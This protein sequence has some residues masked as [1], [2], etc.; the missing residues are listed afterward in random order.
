MPF[1]IHKFQQL[2]CDIYTSEQGLPEGIISRITLQNGCPSVSGPDGG[3]TL[4]NKKWSSS[5]EKDHSSH[6]DH[7]IDLPEGAPFEY[8]CCHIISPCGDEWYGGEYGVALKQ[9]DRWRYFYGRRWL[10]DNHVRCIISDGDNGVWAGTEHGISHL[11]TKEMTLK[12]KARF[13]QEVTEKRHIRQGYVAECALVNA[14]DTSQYLP[15]ATPNEGLWTGLYTASQCFRFAATGDPSAAKNAREAIH[16]MI[17]LIR[18]TG[19]PGFMARSMV[20]N[21]ER[22]MGCEMKNGDWKKGHGEY[23]DYIWR[24]DPSSDEVDGHYLAWYLY[25]ELVADEE[26]KGLIRSV[27]KEVTD[28]ILE[29]DFYLVGPHGKTTSWGIWAPEKLNLDPEWIDERGLNSLEILSH[30]RVAYHICGE[31]RYEDAYRYL[32]KE[33][34]YA[35]NLVNQKMLPPM[36]PDN[37]S[38]D[39]LAWCAYYPLLSIENDPELRKIYLLSLEKTWSILKPQKSPFHNFLYGGLT[40]KPCDEEVS[41]HWLCDAPLD[42][43]DWTMLNSHRKDIEIAIERGRLGELQTNHVLPISEKAITKWNL[44]PYNLDGGSGGTVELDGT[45]WLLPYWFGRYHH[46]FEEVPE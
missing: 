28:H 38:D 18:V 16:A 25:Y 6:S 32:I 39:E 20:A 1:I 34:G 27:C 24:D 2:C 40:G 7:L 33:H 9:G 37:H 15:V 17:R 4:I 3:A 13:F 44:N 23:A 8:A 36:A 45:F 43:I 31:Q 26:E 35:I 5:E 10:P 11:Y 41:V 30:L 21:L 22:C 42:L 14:G 46:L 19:L 12:E 29:N